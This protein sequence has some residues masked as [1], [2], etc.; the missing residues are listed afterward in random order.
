MKKISINKS[1]KSLTSDQFKEW[2]ERR[3]DKGKFPKGEKWESHYNALHPKEDTKKADK[4][5]KK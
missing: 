3:Q 4:A 5:D 2:F 1:L